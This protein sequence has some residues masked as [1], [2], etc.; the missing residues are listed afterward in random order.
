MTSID[1]RDAEVQQRFTSMKKANKDAEK[2]L[3]AQ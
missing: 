3:L 2:E 1:L